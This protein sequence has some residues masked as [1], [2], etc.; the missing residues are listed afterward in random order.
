MPKVRVLITDFSAGMMDEKMAARVDSTIQRKA[1][2]EIE[3]FIVQPDGGVR[4]RSGTVL[5]VEDIGADL[6]E[7]GLFDPDGTP[8]FIVLQRGE[9][10]AQKPLLVW[11]RK[12]PSERIMARDLSDGTEWELAESAYAGKPVTSTPTLYAEPIADV[13]NQFAIFRRGGETWKIDTH[14]PEATVWGADEFATI[15][16]NRL[17]L[18]ERRWGKI[19]TSVPLDLLNFDL[20]TTD[21]GTGE[22]IETGAIEGI[23]D[24]YGS[25]TARWILSKARLYFGTDQAEYEVR[26]NSGVLSNSLGD[27]QIVK[28][29]NVGA[30]QA[31]NFGDAMVLRKGNRLTRI[32]WEEDE[33]SYQ[34]VSLGAHL[35]FANII[36][37][38]TVEQGGHR[39]LLALD[40]TRTLWCLTESFP[41]RVLGFT[42]VMTDVW[43]VWEHKGDVFVATRPTE[44]DTHLN[45][46]ALPMDTVDAPGGR[47]EIE[48]LL[49]QNNYF[50]GDRSQYIKVTSSGFSGYDLPALSVTQLYYWSGA[51]WK[52]L[53]MCPTTADG[54]LNL[55]IADVYG[56]VEPDAVGVVGERG[57]IGGDVVGP[58]LTIGEF[59]IVGGTP[60]GYLT[61]AV[62]PV[63]V[64]AYDTAGV[65]VSR[66]KTLPINLAT[67]A[68]STLS[69]IKG[70]V[71]VTVLVS[72]S[73]SFRARVNNGRWETFATEELYTGPV[74][75]SLEGVSA[76][77][78]QVEIESIGA[79]PLTVMAIEADVTV[80]EV[81]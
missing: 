59:I 17:I 53:I 24:F 70:V 7:N 52:K 33:Q 1:A 9:S 16:D 2:A 71:G 51:D 35:N 31:I 21:S 63:Y 18:I 40:V 8:G 56:E 12:T 66:L 76:Q 69:N 45:I 58:T 38:V 78:V 4:R 54:S 77:S 34:S 26:S 36:H 10:D 43:W 49:Q 46:E 75:L 28:I 44:S 23:P 57:P 73:G 37:L 72:D 20:T 62:D 80:G 61:R 14:T 60:I 55:S 29:G 64:W 25:E 3:G 50:T 19:R 47:E 22:T 81:A 65:P 32:Q 5:M 48:K 67:D 68:G 27:F 6:P 30:E 39:Y 11:S 74:S 15:H 41:Q 42:R 79:E 13:E